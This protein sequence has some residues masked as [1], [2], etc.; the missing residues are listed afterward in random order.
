MLWGE[1]LAEN[2]QPSIVTELRFTHKRKALEGIESLLPAENIGAANL[3]YD[4]PAAFTMS[5]IGRYIATTMPPTTT[6][7]KTIMAGS[8]SARRPETAASTS[9]S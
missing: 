5:K 6:P 3:N 9:S 8:I 1:Y 4:Q 2:T 7:R